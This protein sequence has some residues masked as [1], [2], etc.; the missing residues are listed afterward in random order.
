MESPRTTV[1]KKS[2]WGLKGKLII[3]MLLVGVVPLVV[4]LVMAFYV[5]YEEIR[6]V[7]GTNF[8]AIATETARKLDLVLT[9]EVSRTRRI[10][11]DPRIIKT[12]EVRRDQ[13]TPDEDRLAL[14]AK[15][16][17]GWAKREPELVKA[18][19]QNDLGDLL[20]RYY[21]GP[22]TESEQQVPVVTRSAKR[23]LFITDIHGTLVASINADA[24]FANAQEEWFQGA[25]NRGVGQAYIT[26]VA[27]DE[28]FK[29]FTFSLSL[30]IMDSIRY[31][32]VGV[33]HQVYDAKEFL[34]PSVHPIRFGKTGHV[35]LIDTAGTVITCPILPTGVRLA[36]PRLIELVTPPQPGWVAAPSSGHGDQ[37]DSLIAS[38]AGAIIGYAR[39][40]ETSRITQSSTNRAWHTFVWESSD[41]LFAPV[42]HLLSWISVFGFV[43]I[44]LLVTLGYMAAGRIV[45]PIRRLQ[46]AALLIGRGE[47]KERIQIKTGDEIEDLAEE[48]NRMNAQL[49]VAFAGLTDQ[50]AQKT[51]EVQYLQQVTDQ[52][53]DSMVTPIVLLGPEAR[54]EY[55][56]RAAKEAFCLEGQEG[57]GNNLFDL[58][59]LDDMSQTRLEVE[60]DALTAP[61]GNGKRDLADEESSRDKVNL[62][63]PLKPQLASEPSQARKEVQIGPCIYNYE[64]FEISARGSGPRIGLILRNVTDESRRQDQLIQAEK[65]GSMG[66]LAAGIGHELNNPL[67]GILGLGEA[68]QDETD[69]GKIKAYAKDIVG[70]GNRMA[71]TIRDFTGMARSNAKERSSK[72]DIND[73][74]DQA[75]RLVPHDGENEA[76]QVETSYQPLQS[77]TAVPEELRQVFVNVIANAMQAM[78]RRGKL[79]I[80]TQIQDGIMEIRVH[81]TGPGIPKAFLSK[82]FDPFFTTKGQGEGSG[83]GLTVANRIVTKYGGRMQLS[84]EE[85]QGTTCLITFPLPDYTHTGERNS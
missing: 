64:W 32:A 18:L 62:R 21:T 71:G 81:D 56:N 26:D 47:L 17:K 54:V 52:I 41:E 3:S 33:L 27:F 1:S 79:T 59:P 4:G 10:T 28:R 61:G 60:L 2:R 19:T 31:Q 16:A 51:E 73:Q 42:E 72:V 5:G 25:F 69:L 44:G 80:S 11:R 34:A 15:M 49:E 36:D 70:H 82:V 6:M 29:V 39:L 22:T 67:F 68:I 35:M 65:L 14:E 84:S 40:P 85:G 58:L 43:A 8:A 83:L 23:A 30:P 78:K 20:R 63:D 13:A 38:I 7:S 9:E 55:I 37:S 12:L 75:L 57:E 74:L 77:I 24:S 50:V 48:I 45:T 46:E 66:V 76:V 53:L